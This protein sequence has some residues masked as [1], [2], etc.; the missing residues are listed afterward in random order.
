MR[1]PRRSGQSVPPA[2]PRASP[3]AGRERREGERLLAYW[4]GALEE[5][6]E[7]ITI[8]SLDITASTGNSGWSN[9]FLISVDPFIERS[10]LIMYGAK[11]AALLG[12]PEQ[13]RA[14]QPL[15]RQLP[16]RYGEV[17]IEGCTRAQ[18]ESTPVHLAGEV[19]RSDGRAE[20]YRAVFIPVGVRPNALTCF[21][22]G[23]FSCRVFDRPPA[24]G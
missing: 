24:T 10:V 22:F 12:L 20:R 11:F 2:A 13:P 1:A 14:D 18:T 23:A 7:G 4:D 3:P 8:A 15:L 9:R 19:A 16:Q 5:F 6:G 21:A 17:F